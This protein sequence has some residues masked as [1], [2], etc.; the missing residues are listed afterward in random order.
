[1]ES[2]NRTQ[3]KYLF[4][5]LVCLAGLLC[6][7][8]HIGFEYKVA[9][10]NAAALATPKKYTPPSLSLRD[11]PPENE[12]QHKNVRIVPPEASDID[13]IKAGQQ[14]IIWLRCRLVIEKKI[15]DTWRLR[16]IASYSLGTQLW[17]S[18][19]VPV[20]ETIEFKIQ[21]QLDFRQLTSIRIVAFAGDNP[22]STI[23]ISHDELKRK[24]L[25]QNPA[26]VNFHVSAGGIFEGYIVDLYGS[27][28]SDKRVSIG[29]FAL[30]NGDIRNG[31][32]ITRITKTDENG[33]FL[34]DN[35]LP[36]EY[37]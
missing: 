36:G 18:Q 32:A 24:M 35:L 17:E 30:K 29:G 21:P 15:Y 27:G 5:I 13:E 16:A 22:I 31:V 3:N 7:A 33:Y 11:K 1:M 14:K 2:K 9:K 25:E 34:I 19:T 4:F 6:V 23:R 8:Q 20:E 37:I 12:P 10:N 26:E 28:L